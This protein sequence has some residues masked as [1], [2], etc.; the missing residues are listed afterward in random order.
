MTHGKDLL[1]SN[2]SGMKM[3]CSEKNVLNVLQ[4]YDGDID[5]KAAYKEI[6]TKSFP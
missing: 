4:V 6:R 1:Y 5:V 2:N 3:I